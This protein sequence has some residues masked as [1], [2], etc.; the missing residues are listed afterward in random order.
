[1]EVSYKADGFNSMI[2]RYDH[3]CVNES[4]GRGSICGYYE[5]GTVTYAGKLCNLAGYCNEVRSLT[6]TAGTGFWPVT[7]TVLSM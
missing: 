1:M 6:L 3:G 2:G 5:N 4:G 7:E